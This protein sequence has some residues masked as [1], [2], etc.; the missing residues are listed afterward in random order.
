M[1]EPGPAPEPGAT[2]PGDGAVTPAL[3]GETPAVRFRGVSKSFGEV[4][5]LHNVD[6]DVPAGQKLAIIGPSGSGKTTLLRLIMTLEQPEQGFIEVDGE[7]LGMERRDGKVVRDDTRRIRDVRAKIGMVFQHFNLFPHMTALGNVMEGPIHVNR[8]DRREA[9]QRA[10]ELLD[11]VGLAAKA[12][13]YPRQLSG[14]QQQ[15]VAIARALAMRPR[16]ML[17]DEVTSALDPELVGEVLRVVRELAHQESMTMLIVTHEMAFAEEISDR[18]I[19]MDHGVIVEDAQPS[20]IFH[21][22]AHERTRAFLRAVL[23]R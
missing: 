14:G 4:H 23:E 7:L 8:V 17:F 19:F 18:V 22:P 16:V 10:R 11:L 21:H 5:V 2:A 1:P 9:E 13:A 20:V 12:D 6:L 15:R 3:D